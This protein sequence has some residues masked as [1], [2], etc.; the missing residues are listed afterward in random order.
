MVCPVSVASLVMLGYFQ[1]MIWFWLYPCVLTISFAFLLHSRLHTWL[2]ALGLKDL[3]KGR[4]TAAQ[5]GEESKIQACVTPLALVRVAAQGLEVTLPVW[6]WHCTENNGY[7]KVLAAEEMSCSADGKRMQGSRF[8]WP[9]STCVEV[10]QGGRGCGVPEANASVCC[11]AP[12]GEQAV[13]V[14][15]PGNGLDCCRVIRELEHG[16]GG[17]LVPDVQLVI[18]AA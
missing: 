6:R 1:A 3:T 4:H 9:S 7:D 5:H 10:V 12:R 8:R 16:V 15:R 11:A 14:R 18:I 13:L 2:P 17:L